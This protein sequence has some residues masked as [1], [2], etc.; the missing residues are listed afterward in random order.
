MSTRPPRKNNYQSKLTKLLLF[1]RKL[2]KAAQKTQ[3]LAFQGIIG[4]D[5]VGRGSLIGP[6]IAAACFFPDQSLSKAIK[7]ELFLLD[8]SKA[9][10][11]THAKR[12][13]L[14]QTLKDHFAWGIGEATQEEVEVL[15]VAQASLLAAHRAVMHLVEQFS[16]VDP[17]HCLTCMDGR[18]ALPHYPDP[19]Q[20]VIKGD[21]QSAAIAAASIIAKAYR[22][23]LVIR[24]AEDYPYYEWERNA[25]YPTPSHQKAIALYGLT[26]LHRKT[27]KI[28]R[29]HLA[30]TQS[31]ATT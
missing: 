31:T 24:L 14:S 5:E 9:S 28:A 4:V 22:D 29:E 30:L 1:D 25:G 16:E 2:L 3:E 7:T 8:D 20:A 15:N 19:Q 13:I 6:V 10:H 26:P 23:E 21:A 27:Y 12:L 11:L 17:S 18:S